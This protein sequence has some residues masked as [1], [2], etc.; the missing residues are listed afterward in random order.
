MHRHAFPALGFG[1]HVA[2]TLPLKPAQH[3]DVAIHFCQSPNVWTFRLDLTDS[4][5]SGLTSQAAI[6]HERSFRVIAMKVR[7]TSLSGWP[8]F[9]LIDVRKHV[10]VQRFVAHHCELN[11]PVN[12][13]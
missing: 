5:S 9:E 13:H 3:L 4:E 1:G 2:F 8:T 10:A 12:S 6:G 11:E 7:P